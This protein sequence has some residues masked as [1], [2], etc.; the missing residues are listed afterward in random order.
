[1]KLTTEETETAL[2]FSFT[3]KVNAL[4]LLTSEQHYQNSTFIHVVQV[5][6]GGTKHHHHHQLVCIMIVVCTVVVVVVVVKVAS[7]PIF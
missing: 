4:E 7:F 5:G 6:F 2:D 3:E 1:M